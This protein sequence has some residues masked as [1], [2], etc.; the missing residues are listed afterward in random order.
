MKVAHRNSEGVLA[1]AIL[2]DHAVI[3]EA[4][5]QDIK[6][7]VCEQLRISWR[8]KEELHSEST[9]TGGRI[10]IE[11]EV[12]QRLCK[13]CPMLFQVKDSLKKR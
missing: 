6:E 7:K 1:T 11:Q 12:H 13:Q 5:P 10:K 4:I 2:S 3:L 9:G 8:M